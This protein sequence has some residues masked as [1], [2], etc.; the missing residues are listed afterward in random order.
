MKGIEI[1]RERVKRRRH[2]RGTTS[3]NGSASREW[4]SRRY[5]DSLESLRGKLIHDASGDSYKLGETSSIGRCPDSTVLI[6]DTRVSRR[7]ALIRRQEDGYWFFDLG[8]S[9]GSFLNENRV[10][11][12]QPLHDGDHLRIGQ[13]VFVFQARGK[14]GDVMNQTATDIMTVDVR[15]QEALILV[16]DIQ[17]FTAL[18]E[19]LDPDQLAPIIGTWYAETSRI[20]AEHGATLDKFIG[21]CV[22]AYWMET[23]HEKRLAALETAKAMQSAC[24]EVQRAHAEVLSEVGLHFR[25]GAAIHLGPVACGGFG[26]LEFTL[27]GDAVNLTFRL[28]ALTRKIEERALV[29]TE[30]LEDWEEGR[31]HCRSLGKRQFKGREQLVEVFAIE[32]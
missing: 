12:A 13:H 14:A 24:D 21:D 22:L 10:T 8:S 32:E 29:T 5:S 6:D 20:L 3:W 25:A 27:L 9:N 4:D 11:T 1:I 2:A 28:E 16:S 26:A 31:E 15:S 7:H 19:R 17:G 18:S 30:V 23:S